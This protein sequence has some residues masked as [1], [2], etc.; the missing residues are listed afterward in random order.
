MKL[1][2]SNRTEILANAL[3]SQVRNDPLGPFDAETIVVQSRGM[4]RWLTLSLAEQLGVWSNPWFPF[5]RTAIEQVLDDLDHGPSEQSRRYDPT[6]LK[7]TIAELLSSDPPE[8][9]VP[10]LGNAVDAERALRLAA[11]VASV[12]D[13]YVVYRPRLLETWV[14]G[15]DSHWQ[16]ELWR[17]VVD[18]LGPHDLASRIGRA[19]LGLNEASATARIRLKRIHLFSLETLPR[20]FLGF[21]GAMSRRIPTHLYLL[22]PTTEYVSDA[23]DAGQFSL[24]ID[25]PP[26][27][28]GHPMLTSLGTLTRDFQELLLDAES[29]IEAEEERFSTPSRNSLL[30]SLQADVLEFRGRPDPAD[31][32]IVTPADRSISI[33]A[34]TSPMREVMVL[35]DVIRGTLEEDSSLRPEDIVVMASDLEAYAPAFRAVFGQANPHRIP[36]EVHDRRTRDDA[37]FYEDFLAVLEVLESR[38]SVLDVVRLMDSRSWR[39]EFQFSPTERAR[40]TGLLEDSGIRWGIDAG[41]REALGFPPEALHTWRAGLG[42]L[43]LGFANAPDTAEA[44]DGLLP[45]GD[46]TLGDANLVARLSRLCGILFDFHEKMP[47]EAAIG[48]WASALGRLANDLFAEEEDATGAVRTL[49]ATLRSLEEAASAQGYHR[50]VRLR[51]VRRELASAVTAGTPPAGFLRR[52]VTLSELV[53]LRS[54]PFRMVCLLGMSEESFPRADDRPSFDLVRTHP[55]IGDR[56]KRQDDRHSFLQ[57]VLCARDRLAITYSAAGTSTRSTPSPAPPVLDLI[58]TIDHYYRRE[59][60]APVLM[61][62]EHPLHAFDEAYFDGNAPLLSYSERYAAVSRAMLAPREDGKRIE[63]TAEPGD[64]PEILPITELAQ[65]IWHPTREFIQRQLQTRFEDSA[66][67]EPSGAL[68]ELD[69]LQGFRVGN[70]ALERRLRGSELQAFLSAAPEFPDGSWGD[71][72]RAKLTLE[73]ES[74]HRARVA[75]VGRGDELRAIIRAKVGN[76][77]LEGRLGGI[78]EDKRLKQRFNRQNTKTE[79]TTWVEHLLMQVSDASELPKE[80]ELLLRASGSHADLVTLRPVDDAHALLTKL[81]TLY[82]RSRRQP[83]ALLNRHSFSFATRVHEGKNIDASLEAVSKA[84]RNEQSWDRYGRFAWGKAGPFVDPEWAADFCRTTLEVYDPLLRHRTV[85]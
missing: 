43:F 83:V 59:D 71:A 2:R 48:A 56:S 82:E 72:D 41:H 74:L 49:R 55:R 44:F 16:A 63:L 37:S 53:P 84:H 80:T 57:T 60:S 29:S 34:C 28:D 67:Y 33:H 45:R 75:R 36:F 77:L 66:L 4:E 54:I 58:E 20:L 68:T 11:S 50:T 47:S 81:V 64:T 23:D 31:R 46:L 32:A 38:F 85:R 40:L 39:H 5:P 27:G 7:W 6:A 17:R 78:Y 42:R 73:V 79:L 62:V 14:R 52:G 18:A 13:E 10:Y 65:W 61:P 30:A 76:V 70:E 69:R 15:R 19:L 22:T 3:A 51:A 9:L 21:F 25:A 12:F 1:V 24:G 35:H 26:M 8:A